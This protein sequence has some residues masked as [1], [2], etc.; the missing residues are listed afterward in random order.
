M[1]LNERIAWLKRMPLRWRILFGTQAIILTTA[2]R[3][4]INDIQRAKQ[5]QIEMDKQDN[6]NSDS[7]SNKNSNTE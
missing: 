4:R 7:N 6:G 5:M 3:F 1:N 2:I